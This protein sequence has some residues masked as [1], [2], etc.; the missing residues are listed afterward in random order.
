MRSTETHIVLKIKRE[1]E[2]NYLLLTF[3]L[4]FTSCNTG[5]RDGKYLQCGGV[6]NV[7][8]FPREIR[9]RASGTPG[10]GFGGL[11]ELLYCRLHVGV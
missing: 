6:K 2:K 3:V 4:V 5:Y 7:S 9:G 8:D 1:Y 10:Y 11:R